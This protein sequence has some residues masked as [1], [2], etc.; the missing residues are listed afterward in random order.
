MADEGEETIDGIWVKSPKGADVR[1][2]KDRVVNVTRSIEEVR[3]R[4]WIVS[5]D[6]RICLKRTV[7]LYD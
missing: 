1:R 2:E 4:V 7:S 3:A 5:P 6:T